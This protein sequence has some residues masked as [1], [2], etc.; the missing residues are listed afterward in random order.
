MLTFQ[1]QTAAAER[2]MHHFDIQRCEECLPEMIILIHIEPQRN[3]DLSAGSP[4]FARL[5]TDELTFV[6]VRIVLLERLLG[7]CWAAGLDWPF[8]AIARDKLLSLAEGIDR[9]L[10]V[11][12]AQ[13]ADA[14]GNLMGKLR[15]LM[16]IH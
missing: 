5:L 4:F 13:L 9:Q 16:L 15:K 2:R 8:A 14:S 7:C 1:I 3:T 10:T 12:A 6:F 11:I